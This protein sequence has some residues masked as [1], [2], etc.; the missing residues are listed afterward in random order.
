MDNTVIFLIVISANKT[1][2]LAKITIVLFFR[3]IVTTVSLDDNDGEGEERLILDQVAE[4][5]MKA[6][7]DSQTVFTGDEETM[8]MTT[9]IYAKTGPIIGSK[10]YIRHQIHDSHTPNGACSPNGNQ[11]NGKV[12]GESKKGKIKP[13]TRKISAPF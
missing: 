11:M 4:K 2:H 7:L 5:D 1:C 9:T 6:N 12:N 8:T 3:C 13:E 10:K